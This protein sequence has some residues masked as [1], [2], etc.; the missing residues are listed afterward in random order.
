MFE[1]P[2]DETVSEV[3]INEECITSKKDPEIIRGNSNE[4]L[5]ESPKIEES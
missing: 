5:L 2:S 1:V 3:I 4:N